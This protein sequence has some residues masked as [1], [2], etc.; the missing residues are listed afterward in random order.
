M[1]NLINYTT[2]RVNALINWDIMTRA[3]PTKKSAEKDFRFLPYHEMFMNNIK[4]M[5]WITS[6]VFTE[7]GTDYNIANYFRQIIIDTIETDY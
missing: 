4:N 5:G 1:Y 7:S 6:L 2:T 3:A